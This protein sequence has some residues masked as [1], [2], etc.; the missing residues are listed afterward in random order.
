MANIIT[1]VMNFLVGRMGFNLDGTKVL[2][3]PGRTSGEPRSV[4]VNPLNLK[5][6]S[7]L[8]SPR[9][10]TQWVK[11]V[12]AAGMLSLH[13]GRDVETYRAIEVHDPE[14]KLAVIRAYLE[15]WG[16][17]VKGLMGVDK[18]SSDEALGAILDKHPV[19]TLR[20]KE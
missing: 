7:Y 2:T 16:W 11:N 5:G 15:R 6:I 18:G 19:F 4:V 13:R 8:V 12:R 3:V 17:P 9:G 14:E 1:K 10:E 20:R